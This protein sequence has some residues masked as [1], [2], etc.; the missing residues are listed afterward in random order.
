MISP[1]T[2]VLNAEIIPAVRNKI[3]LNNNLVFI[4]APFCRQIYIP[5]IN[6]LLFKCY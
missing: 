1:I 2:S 6:L 3:E 4:A 5:V